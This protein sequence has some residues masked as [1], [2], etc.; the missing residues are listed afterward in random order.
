MAEGLETSTEGFGSTN[1]AQD[2]KPPVPSSTLSKGQD[3]T[4]QVL[5]FLSSASNETLIGCLLALAA[6]TYLVLGRI[7]LVLIG[8]VGGVVL[9]AS[10][11]SS[12][13]SGV[14][15]G[16]SVAEIKRRK[17]VGLDVVHRVLDWRDRR[18]GN[19]G[20]HG[21]DGKDNTKVLSTQKALSFADFQPAT[22]AALSSLVDAVIRDYVKYLNLRT[23]DSMES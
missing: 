5:Q 7:G 8:V 18:E 17:E 16:F 10:W 21:S 11:E 6:T 4:N 13:R 22:G 2:I 14:D 15:D 3:I 9:H 12:I 19:K 23:L 1:S 20:D